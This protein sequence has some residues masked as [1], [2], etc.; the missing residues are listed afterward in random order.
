MHICVL[1]GGLAGTLLAWRLRRMGPG[2]SVDLMTG[3]PSVDAT[4]VSGGGVRGYEPGSL[5]RAYAIESMDELLGSALLREWSGFQRIGS[6]YLRPWWPEAAAEAAALPT[7]ARL[8]DATELKDLGWAGLGAETVGV[9]EPDAGH[10]A[11]DAFRRALLAQLAGENRVRI[12]TSPARPVAGLPDGPPRCQVDGAI[13]AYDRVVIAAGAWTPALLAGMG[14]P[15]EH[16]G[17]VKGIQYGL[18]PA[19][20]AL[21]TFFVDEATGLYGRPLSPRA[22]LLGVP[23][24]EYGGPADGGA[25]EPDLAERA[26]AL[27]A[28]RLPH[29]KLGVASTVTRSADCYRQPF[30]LTLAPVDRRSGFFTFTGGSGG[31]A[32]TV[33]AASRH[34][35]TRLIADSAAPRPRADAHTG[36]ASRNTPYALREG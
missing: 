13:R 11:P 30:T 28:D 15:R 8:A 14:V 4:A 19:S 5:P 23:I 33:L 20:G 1:G 22:M 26:S 17:Q 3:G 10:I 18:F 12:I 7:G 27:A 16:C 34:A 9:L 2:V 6:T 29:L 35:A 21:P 36:R 32:K 31:A 24:T 25:P